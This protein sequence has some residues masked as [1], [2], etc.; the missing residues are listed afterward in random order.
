MLEDST[1]LDG[2]TPLTVC[3]KRSLEDTPGFL[4]MASKRVWCSPFI[5]TTKSD[6]YSE[7]ENQKVTESVSE[8]TSFRER[9]IERE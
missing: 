7:R 4:A 8:R 1:S 6:S 3:G 9:E 5:P 2:Q